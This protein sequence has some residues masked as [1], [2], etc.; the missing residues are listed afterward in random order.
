M[1][2]G[3]SVADDRS[4]SS[5]GGDQEPVIRFAQGIFNARIR[6]RKSAAQDY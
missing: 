4:L 5:V 2:P 3:E 6:I 1:D